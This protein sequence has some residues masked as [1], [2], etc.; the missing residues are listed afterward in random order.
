MT[1]PEKQLDRLKA[2]LQSAVTRQDFDGMR[3]AAVDYARGLSGILRNEPN[4]QAARDVLLWAAECARAGRAHLQ[5]ELRHVNAVS[6]YACDE[7][8]PIP[9]RSLIG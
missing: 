2:D 9:G 3:A 1:Q 5:E 7:T 4:L 6:R 8:N